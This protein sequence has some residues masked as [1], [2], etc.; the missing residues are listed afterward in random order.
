MEN[1]KAAKRKA[2]GP[3]SQPLM[4]CRADEIT[5]AA[6]VKWAENQPD[7]PTLSEA[8]RWLVGLALSANVRPDQTSR[9][10]ATKA[11]AM[12]ANQLDQL[13]DPSATAN[14]QAHRNHRRRA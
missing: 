11:N 4:G 9:A 6:I 14:E 3:S 1:G 8:I 7:K 2:I 10:R 13:A 5:R 12:A